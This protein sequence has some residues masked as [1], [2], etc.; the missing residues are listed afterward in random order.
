M[1]TKLYLTTEADFNSGAYSR[2]YTEQIY[3]RVT[4]VVDAQ[5]TARICAGLWIILRGKIQDLISDQVFEPIMA[6]VRE[7][8]I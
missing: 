3:Q 1:L 5:A 6:A 8:D 2:T 7:N 4:L